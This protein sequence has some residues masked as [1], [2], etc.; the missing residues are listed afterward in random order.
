VNAKIFHLM[1]GWAA[2]GL[3]P[4]SSSKVIRRSEFHPPAW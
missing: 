3:P 1:T 4:T 2:A